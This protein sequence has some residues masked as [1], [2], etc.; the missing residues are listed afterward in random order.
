MQILR[1]VGTKGAKQGNQ[2]KGSRTRRNPRFGIAGLL[3][4]LPLQPDKGTKR[5]THNQ[6]F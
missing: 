1:K 3:I 6:G 2:T 5:S 4:P